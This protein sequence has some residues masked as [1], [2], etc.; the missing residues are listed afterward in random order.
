[1]LQ[2]DSKYGILPQFPYTIS[3]LTLL[4]SK[5]IIYLDKETAKELSKKLKIDLFSVY[6]EHLQLLFLK[7][8][9]SQKKRKGLF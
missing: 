8:F 7:Y 5:K 6:R 2:N 4:K 1:L 3:S 9:Y